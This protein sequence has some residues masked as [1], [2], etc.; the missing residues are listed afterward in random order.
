[1]LTLGFGLGLLHALDADHIMAISSLAT[2]SRGN[3][4]PWTLSAMILFCSRWA[5]GHG[6]ILLALTTLFIFA[7]IELPGYVPQLA[8]KLIGL[9]LL[10]IGGWIIYQNINYIMISA[11]PKFQLRV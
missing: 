11:I 3:Q 9:M 7:K 4:K 8:E 5:L 1:M 2:A 6:G 10:F